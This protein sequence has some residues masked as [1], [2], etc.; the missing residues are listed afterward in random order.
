M[1]AKARSVPPK[2][3]GNDVPPTCHW[4]LDQLQEELNED[5]LPIKRSQIRRILEA[6]HIKWQKPR[7]WLDSVDP[8]HPSQGACL[9]RRPVA[10]GDDVK[11]I[12]QLFDR[13]G[14]QFVGGDAGADEAETQ[15]DHS[16][17]ITIGMTSSARNNLDP[18][19]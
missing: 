8:I 17:T 10:D 3:D 12:R 15:P 18:T 4:S 16:P 6:E 9:L 11:A 1:I 5:G 7:T 2:A 19:I 14:V 13:R